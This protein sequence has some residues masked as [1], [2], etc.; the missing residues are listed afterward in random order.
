MTINMDSNVNAVAF[1]SDGSCIV[2]GSWDESVRVWDALTGE[3]KHVLN[4]HTESV[5]SVAFSGDGSC[6]VSGSDDRSV[7]VWDAL[8]GEEGHVLNGH[9]NYVN[10]VAFSSDG[11]RI[12]SGSDDK[13]VR[14][15]VKSMQDPVSRYTREKVAL[16]FTGWLLLLLLFGFASEPEYK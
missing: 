15:W 8:T 13:S 16:E 10:S 5:N 14:M 7:R 11:N 4:G 2:S 12:V 3:Q 6:I 9:T 1:S